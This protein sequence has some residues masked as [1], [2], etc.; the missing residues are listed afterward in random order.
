MV[1]KVVHF[2]SLVFALFLFIFERGEF[3]VKVVRLL[4]IVLPVNW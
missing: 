4:K 3:V 1:T 2:L